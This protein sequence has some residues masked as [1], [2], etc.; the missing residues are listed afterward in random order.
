MSFVY[1]EYL[2]PGIVEK[3]KWISYNYYSYIDLD[4]KEENL[5]LVDYQTLINS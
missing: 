2:H 5:N 4:I 3:Y 1:P